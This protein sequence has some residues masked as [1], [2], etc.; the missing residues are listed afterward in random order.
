MERTVAIYTAAEHSKAYPWR[1]IIHNVDGKEFIEVDSCSPAM[2]RA[3]NAPRDSTKSQAWI[4]NLVKLRDEAIDKFIED[5]FVV[6]EDRMRP[7]SFAKAFLEANVPD[8]L[9][10][11]VPIGDGREPKNFMVKTTNRKNTS[12]VVELTQANVEAILYA[13]KNY[14]ADGDGHAHTECEEADGDGDDGWEELSELELGPVKWRRN[15][16]R[17]SLKVEWRDENGC[18]H[19]K[20][21][22]PAKGNA[23]EVVRFLQDVYDKNHREDSSPAGKKRK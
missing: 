6:D 15:R 4:S 21:E 10:I 13:I 19:S 12:P 9:S 11:G 17:W 5:V 2:N 3:A 20:W 23:R 18:R 16:G 7:Q 8:A 1:P 14:N 22:Q